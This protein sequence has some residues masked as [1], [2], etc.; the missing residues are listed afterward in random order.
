MS[1]DV[2]AEYIRMS[3]GAGP[4]ADDTVLH[5]SLSEKMPNFG[6]RPFR[7][8]LDS[9]IIHGGF[10]RCVGTDLRK[11]GDEREEKRP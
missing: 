9:F 7:M 10:A 1:K 8:L 2:R 3:W 6:R 11:E 5:N 4:N